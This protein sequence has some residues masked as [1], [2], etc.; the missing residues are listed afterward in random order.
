LRHDDAQGVGF[1]FDEGDGMGES[2][3]DVTSG[4]VNLDGLSLA[5][6]DSYED[7]VLAPSLVPL[8]RQVD[9]PTRSIG[10]HNS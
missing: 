1:E 5:A 2:P 3:A 4:L 6:L 7:A 8:L 9:R 10:G